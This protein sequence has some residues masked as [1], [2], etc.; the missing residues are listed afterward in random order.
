MLPRSWWVGGA[1][2]VVVAGGCGDVDGVRPAVEA[3]IYE[4]DAPAGHLPYAVAAFASAAAVLQDG[5]AAIGVA[6]MGQQSATRI[7]AAKQQALTNAPRSPESG[8]PCC[9]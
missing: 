4:T 1:A 9:G 7:S 3:A 8:L 5:G 6:G 2:E